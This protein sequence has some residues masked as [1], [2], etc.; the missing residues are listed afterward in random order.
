MILTIPYQAFEM[1]NVHVTPF[2]HDRYGK[3]IT[4]TPRVNLTWEAY[5]FCLLPIF[6]T[7]NN[8]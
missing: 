8:V 4:K 1:C 6:Y 2:S 7:I 5:M 3:L